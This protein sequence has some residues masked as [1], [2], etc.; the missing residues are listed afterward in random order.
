MTK[1]SLLDDIL[2]EDKSQSA[3]EEDEILAPLLDEIN[4]INDEG[5]R[6]FVRSILL[7]ANLF[8][9]IP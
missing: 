5:I 1:K 4:M 3:K 6:F 7:K 2:V 8:W 9:I